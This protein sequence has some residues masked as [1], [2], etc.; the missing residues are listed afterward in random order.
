M[1][2]HLISFLL[3]KI[4]YYSY[5]LWVWVFHIKMH[6]RNHFYHYLL[7]KRQFPVGY[8][9]LYQPFLGEETEAHEK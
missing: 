8:T 1:L 6:F 7:L 5:I 4:G 3:L 9:L 2:L